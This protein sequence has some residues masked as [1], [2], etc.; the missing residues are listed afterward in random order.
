MLASTRINK[1]I[2][3]REFNW[4]CLAER[5]PEM[6]FLHNV[7]LFW[8]FHRLTAPVVSL[9]VC[10]HHGR[11]Y[12]FGIGQGACRRLVLGLATVSRGTAEFLAEGERLQ[13][14]VLI[15]SDMFIFQCNSLL[16]WVS[17]Q[18]NYSSHVNCGVSK[19]MSNLQFV[20]FS[21]T[22]IRIMIKADS[23][24]N[25]F[26]FSPRCLRLA[27]IYFPCFISIDCALLIDFTGQCLTWLLF[28][29]LADD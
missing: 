5:H 21:Q 9:C 18:S 29:S 19:C 10:L 24:F 4:Y 14:K 27:S 20:L 6:Q 15:S 26:S 12:T 11:C 23:T 16:F 25:V 1:A 7:M 22:W 28:V 13:P 8:C 3:F 2:H 17:P